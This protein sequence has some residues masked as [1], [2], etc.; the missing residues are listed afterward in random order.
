MGGEEEA[1]GFW[2]GGDALEEGEGVADAVGG[3]GGKGGGGEGAVDA[4]DL[5]E[6]GGDRAVGVPQDGG[7]VAEDFPL[8]AQLQ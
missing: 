6:E 4:A 5:L 7:E 8:L 1:A 3:V 2:V